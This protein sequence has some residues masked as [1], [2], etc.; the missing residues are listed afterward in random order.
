[1]NFVTKNIMYLSMTQ[2][3]MKYITFSNI[4]C[5]YISNIMYF[6]MFL[7]VYYITND[8][9]TMYL[10]MVGSQCIGTTQSSEGILV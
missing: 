9:T 4:L 5:F 1:M 2:N 6:I 7:V 10:G 8:K 3:I